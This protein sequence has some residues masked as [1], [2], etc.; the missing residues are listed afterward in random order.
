MAELSKGGT[1][2][3]ADSVFC[4]HAPE[5]PLQRHLLR[6]ERP[7]VREHARPGV[8]DGEQPGHVGHLSSDAGSAGAR[9]RANSGRAPPFSGVGS[10]CRQGRPVYELIAV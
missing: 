3:P 8:I 7:H 6:G 5:R 2:S 1:L 10:Y 9:Y 4:E